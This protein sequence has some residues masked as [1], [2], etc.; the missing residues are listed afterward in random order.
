MNIFTRDNTNDGNGWNDRV[1]YVPPSA[2]HGYPSR[3]PAVCPGES[4]IA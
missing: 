1:S 4:S 3:F 2:Y